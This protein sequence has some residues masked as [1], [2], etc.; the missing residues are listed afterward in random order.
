MKVQ[1]S[2]TYMR[3]E[4]FIFG[5]EYKVQVEHPCFEMVTGIDIVKEQIWIAF[6]GNT[7]LK[8]SDVNQ[9]TRN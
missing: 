2:N 9:G 7:A 1:R 3:M 8:Q 5:N 4:N 6:F